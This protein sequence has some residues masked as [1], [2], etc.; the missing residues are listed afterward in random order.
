MKKLMFVLLTVLSFSCLSYAGGG[1]EVFY[2]TVC[3]V[4]KS[5]FANL[6]TQNNRSNFLIQWENVNYPKGPKGVGEK[7]FLVCRMIN[8]NNQKMTVNF[9]HHGTWQEEYHSRIIPPYSSW[10]I[11]LDDTLESFINNTEINYHLTTKPEIELLDFAKK[12]GADFGPHEKYDSLIKKM[13][14]I[15][16]IYGDDPGWWWVGTKVVVNESDYG[17][18]YLYVGEA[19][20]IILKNKNHPL[21]FLR[22]GSYVIKY[23]NVLGSGWWDDIKVKDSD[24]EMGGVSTISFDAYS[25][26]HLTIE[27]F[28]SVIN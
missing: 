25:D 26:D 2:D 6:I 5:Q 4:S 12:V 13:P 23:Y 24:L 11:Y 27:A 8:L 9:L 1:E 7:K 18:C 20:G 19:E 21:A 22:P 15:K 14:N 28:N 17:Q 10:N 16:I 3:K